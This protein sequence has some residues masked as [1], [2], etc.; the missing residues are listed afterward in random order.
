MERRIYGDASGQYPALIIAM[1]LNSKVPTLK[2]LVGRPFLLLKQW[3]ILCSRR[4]SQPVSV[5]FESSGGGW[6]LAG[7]FCTC[8]SGHSGPF[9]F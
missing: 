6:L 4:I 8:A 9:Y 3:V 7:E 5:V 1:G 2:R